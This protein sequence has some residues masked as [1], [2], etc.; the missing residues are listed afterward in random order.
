MNS[1]MLSESKLDVIKEIGNI[2]AGN[3]LISLSKILDESVS[4]Q[5]PQIKVL[6]YSEV[7][8]LMGGAENPVLAVLLDFMGDI[9]G[10]I[11]LVLEP[12]YAYSLLKILRNKEINDISELEEVDVSAIKEVGN[13]LAGSYL[14]SLSRF[15]NIDILPSVPYFAYD[16]AGAVISVPAI[17]FGQMSDNIIY[18]ETVF[19]EGKNNI[20][21]KC[22]LIPDW[23][24]Y[25]ILLNMLG[26]K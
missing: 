25:D 7:A 4:M 8:E 22:F 11:M 15:C 16:M 3:A 14:S 10:S 1:K 5:V 13:I 2:G 24:S 9:N 20:L 26:V 18:I 17:R 21:G 19:S 6:E 12:Q 23:A